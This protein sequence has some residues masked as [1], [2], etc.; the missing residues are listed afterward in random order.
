MVDTPLVLLLKGGIKNKYTCCFLLNIIT[1]SVINLYSSCAFRYIPLSRLNVALDD[2]G[3]T[4]RCS[5]PSL[6]LCKEIEVT[7]SSSVYHCKIGDVDAAAKVIFKP[8]HLFGSIYMMP[9]CF[10]EFLEFFVKYR[11]GI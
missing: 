5:F 9:F 6:L 2:E 10:I 8:L 3:Y 1:L 4:S 11:C 7:A